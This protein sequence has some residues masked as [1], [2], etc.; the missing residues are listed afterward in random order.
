MARAAQT[1]FFLVVEM[2]EIAPPMAPNDAA[3]PA[4]GRPPSVSRMPGITDA[5]TTTIRPASFGAE[6]GV[7]ASFNH[8]RVLPKTAVLGP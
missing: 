4:A 7:M 1:A 8:G 2:M 3:L 5:K 6:V